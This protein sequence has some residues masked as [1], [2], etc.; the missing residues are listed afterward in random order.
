MSGV[1]ILST[2][3]L[4]MVVIGSLPALRRF[5]APSLHVGNRIRLSGGYDAHPT[6]LG[7]RKTID[8]EVL[9]FVANEA[10]QSAIVRLDEII[11]AKDLTSK[12]VRLS[13]RY[14]GARWSSSEIVHVELLPDMP[15]V[16]AS[17]G[18]VWIESHARYRVVS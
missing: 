18:S 10:V 6:W 4:A 14:Q 8:G 15:T 12:I 5:L 11:T 9:D 2:T 7:A 3:L 17:T 16:G 13:L 1:L